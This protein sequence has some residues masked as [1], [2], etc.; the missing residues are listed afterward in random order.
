ML[1]AKKQIEIAR[2]KE[3]DPHTVKRNGKK[4]IPIRFE[5]SKT[6]LTERGY[7]VRYLEVEKVLQYLKEKEII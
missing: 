2:E 5:D 6:R 1:E 7:G 3:I 4:F